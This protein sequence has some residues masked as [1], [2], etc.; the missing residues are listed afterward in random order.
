MVFAIRANS[1]TCSSSFPILLLQLWHEKEC[2][3]AVKPS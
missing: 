1:F 3:V 2:V